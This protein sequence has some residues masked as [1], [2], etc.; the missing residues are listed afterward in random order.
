MQDTTAVI[1]CVYGLFSSFRTAL[2]R[3]PFARTRGPKAHVAFM[4]STMLFESGITRSP[5]RATGIDPFGL[6]SKNQSGFAFGSRNFTVYR[7]PF[8]WA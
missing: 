2:G 4:Y 3:S 5:W 6:I 8:A 1:E 7:M